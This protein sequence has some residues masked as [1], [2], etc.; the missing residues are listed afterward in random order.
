VTRGG[1]VW[2]EL[3]I[4]DVIYKWP[5]IELNLR[6]FLIECHHFL[7]PHWPPPIPCHSSLQLIREESLWAGFL[8]ILSNSLTCLRLNAVCSHLHYIRGTMKYMIWQKHQKIA[9]LDYLITVTFS[10]GKQ[11]QRNSCNNW[12]GPLLTVGK[13]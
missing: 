3:T 6:I 11:P 1:G 5:L 12:Q 7:D 9:N 10:L 2:K 13:S 4:D 8:K